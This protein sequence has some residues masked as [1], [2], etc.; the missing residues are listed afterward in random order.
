MI[1]I[2][3]EWHYICII[4]VGGNELY[5][6]VL[7]GDIVVIGGY[8]HTVSMSLCAHNSLFKKKTSQKAKCRTLF[9]H[10]RTICALPMFMLPHTNYQSSEFDLVCVTGVGANHDSL[11]PRLESLI[12]YHFLQSVATSCRDMRPSSRAGDR[13]DDLRDQYWCWLFNYTSKWNIWIPH[14]LPAD[15]LD[16]QP[17]S[18]Q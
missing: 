3:K 11:A 10:T 8:L 18:T 7:S 16:A 14:T 15:W 1:W 12:L 5:L 9:Y 2:R 6:K 13:M 17:Q 4:F